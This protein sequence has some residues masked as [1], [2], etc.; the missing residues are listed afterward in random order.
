MNVPFLDLK[1]I[2][3]ELKGEIDK[4]V[5]GVLD[6]GWYIMGN[7]VSSF[8]HE[9][10]AYCNTKYCIGVSNG[11]DALHIV[12]KAWGIGPGDEVI[13][14]A[15]TFIAT[16]LAVSYCGATPVPVEPDINTY[17]INP[18]LIEKA[19]TPR[20]KA[21]I[22][23]HLYGNPADMDEINKIAVKYGLHVLEDA[24]QAHGAFYK[25][26]RCGSLGEAAAFSFYPGKNLGALGDGGAITTN[27]EALAEKIKKLRN[28]G[29][30][31]KYNHELKG[32]NAR[33]D[34]IQAAVLRVKLNCLNKVNADRNLWA[35]Y[36]SAKLGSIPQIILP[37]IA[38][39]STSAWHVF[40]IRCEQRNGLQKYLASKGV[41]TLIH[42]PLP[43]NLQPAYKEE[44]G[45]Y[46]YQISE[47]LSE[48]SLS[49][50]IWHSISKERIDY[51]IEQ[52]SNYFS[53]ENKNN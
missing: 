20:T 16:W 31:T 3:G 21:I 2:N 47:E 24:A 6:S 42:Y 44:Y 36:Y 43:P 33:L 38:P 37:K 18:V 40:V 4:A 52:I 35:N 41:Q 27:D 45:Q 14:P 7:E 1:E 8:E 50:P 39:G 17:N 13:V 23:V 11:L 25:G 48:T 22:P 29:S 5:A 28:Y 9:F 10:A 30:A 32:F 12:L 26:K 49:L 46:K 15:N 34:E 19:V 51:V 53:A